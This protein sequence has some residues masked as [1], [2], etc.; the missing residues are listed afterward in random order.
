MT[1]KVKERKIKHPPKTKLSEAVADDQPRLKAQKGLIDKKATMVKAT[2]DTV[3]SEPGATMRPSDAQLAKINEFTRREV[4]ADEVVAFET[5]SCND[6]IDRDEDQFS[7]KCIKEFKELQQPFSSVGKSYMLDHSYSV[8][9]AV[10]RIFG[11]GTKKVS[12]ANFLT[13]E[14]YIPNTESNQKLIEDIDFGVNWAVSVGV[15][16]GKAECTVCQAGFSS[17]GWWCVNGHDKGAWYDPDSDETDAY[18]WP[19]SVDPNTKGAV[20]CIRRFDDPKDFYELSQVFLG[21]QYFASLEKQPDF[22]SVMKSVTSGKVPIVGLSAEEAKKLP[23]RHEH[24][25]VTEARIQFGVSE[26]EDGTLKWID[27]DGLQWLYDPEDPA[28]GVLSLGKAAVSEEDNEQEEDN[29]EAVNSG[30]PGTSL[31]AVD[32]EDEPVVQLGTD[33]GEQG[34]GGD[35][36]AEGGEQQGSGEGSEEL[37]DEDDDSDDDDSED[38]EEDES[39]EDKSATIEQVI[40]AAR[41]AKLPDSV[42]ERIQASKK[43]GVTS[44]ALAVALEIKGLQDQI[45]ALTPKAALGDRL[46]SEKRADAIHWYRLSMATKPDEPVNVETFQK[47]LERVGDDADILDELVKEQKEAAQRKFPKSVRRS[48]FPSDPNKEPEAVPE[49]EFA[50]ENDKKVQRLHG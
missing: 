22:A 38:D 14:V 31:G 33:E 37:E 8:A 50:A 35:P 41:T 40:A 3:V 42:I 39:D 16:L 5:L 17:W 23:L 21:A 26:L 30:A 47:V 32:G 43:D 45:S 13:N 6:L 20:Q 10:G 34:G 49:L 19:K 18:G 25:T 28:S 46:I 44:L 7:S 36:S 29:G 27:D 15:V 2:G 1:T 12:G 11:V 4:T 48:S 9:N 24:P